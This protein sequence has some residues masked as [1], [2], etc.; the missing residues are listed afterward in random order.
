MHYSGL[1]SIFS[2]IIQLA[3]REIERERER[4]LLNIALFFLC[5]MFLLVSVSLL[6]F[7]KV[8]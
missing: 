4:W 1:F 7:L 6:H 3:Q 5:V 8:Q 2:S